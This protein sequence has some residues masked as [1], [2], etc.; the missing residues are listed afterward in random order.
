M[1]KPAGGAQWYGKEEGIMRTAV[2]GLSFAAVAWVALAVCPFKI[3]LFGRLL[4]FNFG[5]RR[6]CSA[7]ALA[8]ALAA[9]AYVWRAGL[10]PVL[11]LV[12]GIFLLSE[13]LFQCREDEKTGH[14]QGEGKLP[15]A[16]KGG[17]A[18]PAR[19]QRSP[20]IFHL[21]LQLLLL[22]DFVVQC[23]LLTG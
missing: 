15:G 3:M 1:E 20:N 8:L 23:F 13:L 6:Q 10:L 19:P 4:T 14:K 21:T 22:A 2:I 17:Q 9:G 5:A 12:T 7:L 16:N 11:T 18:A